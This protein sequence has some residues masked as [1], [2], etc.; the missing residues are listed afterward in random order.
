MNKIFHSKLL[1][2]FVAASITRPL[3]MYANLLHLIKSKL[4]NN[5]Y[6]TATV[7]DPDLESDNDSDYKCKHSHS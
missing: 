7:S 3:Y 5:A 6:D 1:N 4:C 2:T